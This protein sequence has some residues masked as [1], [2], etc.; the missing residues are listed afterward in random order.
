[1]P[2]AFE[3]RIPN[4]RRILR[5]GRC[6]IAVIQVD[7]RIANGGQRWDFYPGGELAG[8]AVVLLDFVIE[9]GQ[10]VRRRKQE[11]APVGFGSACKIGPV[12]A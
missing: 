4:R 12:S 5:V 8:G 9:P 3:I 10:T 1:M 6:R 11:V 7:D 2:H